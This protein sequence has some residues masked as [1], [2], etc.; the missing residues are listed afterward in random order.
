MNQKC[1]EQLEAEERKKIRAARSPGQ[2]GFEKAVQVDQA[3][4]GEWDKVSG[5]IREQWNII[6][7][8][9]LE[10]TVKLHEV[11]VRALLERIQAL[12]NHENRT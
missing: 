3:V 7:H 10:P 9:I 8:A 11:Q 1:K 12:E 2:I 6:A 5:G 4:P